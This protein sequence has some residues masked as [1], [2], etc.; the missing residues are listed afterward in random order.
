M[1]FQKNH[2]ISTVCSTSK[3]TDIITIIFK[4][5]FS[6]ELLIECNAQRLMKKSIVF[7]DTKFFKCLSGRYI[8]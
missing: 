4:N 1:S 3:I 6:R 5:F 7:K 2:W 8:Y